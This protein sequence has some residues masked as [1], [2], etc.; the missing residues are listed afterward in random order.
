MPD[1]STPARA[2]APPFEAEL[3]LALECADGWQAHAQALAHRFAQALAALGEIVLPPAAVPAHDRQTLAT[4]GSLYLVHELEGVVQA[5]EKLLALWASGAVQVHLPKLEPV[6]G[7]AWKERRLRLSGE[8]RRALLALAFNPQEFAPAMQGLCNALTAL[9]DNA[10]QHDVREEVGLQQA[11][12]SLLELAAL[13]LAGAPAVA[14]ADLVAQL[15]EATQWLGDRSLQ[16]AMGTHDLVSLARA[17]LVT[18][19]ALAADLSA[20]LERARGGS[21]VLQWIATH[22]ATGFA[23]DPRDPG[24]QTVIAAAQRWLLSAPAARAAAPLLP[25]IAGAAPPVLAPAAW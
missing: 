22:A 24:L 19:P 20:A 7:R 15:R 17:C 5:A 1:A 6:L 10:Q 23:I 9:A 21:V 16:L 25:K 14:S 18:E 4:L 13:R 3:A 2:A 11:A 8:E 12:A